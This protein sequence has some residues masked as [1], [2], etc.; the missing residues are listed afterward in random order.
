[1]TQS[2]HPGSLR[3]PTLPFQGRVKE[4]WSANSSLAQYLLAP[5]SVAIVGQ[6]N[7]AGKTAGRPLRFLRQAGYAGRIYPVN[8]N[9]DEVLGERAWRSLAALPEVPEHAYIVLPTDAAVD[10]VEECARLGVKVATVLANGFSEAGAEGRARED[11]LRE[12]SARSGIRIVGPS[13]LGVVDLRRRLFLTANA[14]FA[15][16]DLPVGRIFV[17]SH[18]GSMIG[19]IASRGAARGVHFAAFVSVGNEADVSV[20][21]AC[22]AALDDPEIDGFVLF[23]EHLRHAERLRAFALEAAAR[24]KTVI[25]YK[26][27]RSE[28]VRTL[29]QSHT[30]ALVGADDVAEAFLSDCGIA[31]VD[32]FDGLIEGLAL[33]K[34]TP[35]RPHPTAPRRVAAVTT[36]AGGAAM[37]IDQLGL[38]G[39]ETQPPSRETADRLAARGLEM[40]HGN[41]LD[42]T[43]AGTRYEVMKGALDILLAAPEYDLVVAVVGSSAR[44]HPELAVKPIID[45]AGAAKPLAAFL[46]PDAPQALAQLAAAGVPAFRTPEAC[47]DAVAAALKRRP[48]RQLPARAGPPHRRQAK[49]LDELES[50]AV[51]DRLGIGRAP[52]LVLP[53]DVGENPALPF[54]Y[55]V[56]AKILSPDLAHKAACGGV[57]LGIGGAAELRDACRR[58]E[59]AVAEAAPRATRRGILVQPM[60]HGLVEALIGYVIDDD[61]GPC[62]TV[63]RGGALTEAYRDR[64]LRLAPV[65]AATAMQMIGEVR[66]FRAM[67]QRPGAPRPDFAALARAVA[68][69]SQLAHETPPAVLEAE[70][71]PLLVRAEGE[72]VIAVDAV[73]WAADD[74]KDHHA[75]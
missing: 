37:V 15:E 34:R 7:D 33:L 2:P 5:Q 10:A 48:P 64:S 59:R 22:A 65:D 60:A 43:V 25:A 70:I 74:L 14:A 1:M 16:T 42:L 73:V 62:V 68:A 31:R 26:L 6:S 56:A 54:P 41:L 18:S 57:A 75:P 66:A 8:A 4:G 39:I 29:A 71:N 28:A 24:A 9:R 67:M 55:P 72:G 32:T 61:V 3:S 13:S 52:S 17:G 12:I 51:L 47:A 69:L 46:V 30:G 44:F 21:D 35:P 27:G 53:P 49:M 45:S 23:L 20:G 40:T 19:A 38:R 11:R 58:I 50:Y 36:T 63:A